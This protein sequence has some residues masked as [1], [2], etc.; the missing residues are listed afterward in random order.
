MV[1]DP[2][3]VPVRANNQWVFKE[4]Y[5]F[6]ESE[7]DVLIHLNKDIFAECGSDCMNA[8]H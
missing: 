6:N 8:R 1:K 4:S 5:R 3:V 7:S 2:K